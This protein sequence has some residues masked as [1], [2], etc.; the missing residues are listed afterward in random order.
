MIWEIVLIPIGL[1]LAIGIV[2]FLL[3][4]NSP[5]RRDRGGR[6]DGARC[7]RRAAESCRYVDGALAVYLVIRAPGIAALFELRDDVIGHRVGLLF[8]QLFIRAPSDYFAEGEA[9]FDGNQGAVP[10]NRL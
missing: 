7:R 3:S 10:H 6:T 5:G 2:I 4:L 9:A 1:L 8:G